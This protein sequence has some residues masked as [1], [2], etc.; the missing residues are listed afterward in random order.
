MISKEHRKHARLARPALGRFG[1]N[2][3]AFVGA[4]CNHIQA[5]A[6]QVITALS[7]QYHCAY[8]DADHTV[9]EV[10]PVLPGMLAAGA[11]LEYTDAIHSHQLRMN[12]PLGSHQF[13]SLFNESDVILVN[14]NHHEAERQVVII[15]PVKEN[16]LRKRL[17]QLTDVRLILLADGVEKPFDFI[18]NSLPEAAAIP[19]LRLSD[20]AGIIAFFTKE[21]QAQTPLVNGL[22]LAGGQSLRMGR[23]K[24][25][26]TWHGKPQREYMA[27]MLSGLCH[28]VFLACRPDQVV[29]SAYPSITDTFTDLG[30]FGALLSAFRQQ[31]DRAW[32]VVACDLPLLDPATL[33]FLLENRQS[34]RIATAFKNAQDEMPEPLIAVWEPKSYA[35][36]LSFLAQGYS[37]ARKV[38]MNAD[39]LILA[40][41]DPA[42]LTN[43][44]TPEDM[45]TLGI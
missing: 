14:G 44:N 16:S 36:L 1:R 25:A 2:E 22:V 31:P 30:P 4:N 26:I 20:T 32:L 3:W 24:G 21:M 18:E 27:D 10:N 9:A 35:V 28:E 6:R 40:A 33:A 13:R 38:L 29:E 34:R 23:D 41:P 19:R 5:V 45:R 43:V 42:A 7:T 37:C 17:A 11:I 39:A 8:L 12:A 15:D